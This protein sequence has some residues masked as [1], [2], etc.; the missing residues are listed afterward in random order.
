MQSLNQCPGLQVREKEPKKTQT[1]QKFW[2]KR[3]MTPPITSI[4]WSKQKK[5]RALFRNSA[6]DDSD[7]NCVFAAGLVDGSDNKIRRQQAR[8]PFSRDQDGGWRRKVGN[9]GSLT[10]QTGWRFAGPNRGA[11]IRR[12][13]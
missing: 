7:F 11:W 6:L 1:T 10:S 9:D 2:K 13:K 12:A 5:R 8:V 4:C 3:G